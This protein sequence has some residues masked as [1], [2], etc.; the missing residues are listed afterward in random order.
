[1]VD[2]TSPQEAVG[3]AI[4]DMLLIHDFSVS[5]AVSSGRLLLMSFELLVARVVWLYGVGCSFSSGTYE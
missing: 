3:M 1:M 4:R 2:S 5:V